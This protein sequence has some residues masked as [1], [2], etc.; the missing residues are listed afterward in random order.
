MKDFDVIAKEQVTTKPRKKGDCTGREKT[1]KVIFWIFGALFAFIGIV[2]MCTDGFALGL[3]MLIVGAF[4]VYNAVKYKKQSKDA[5]APSASAAPMQSTAPVQSASKVGKMHIYPSVVD[6][7]TVAYYYLLEFEP[8]DGV[9]IAKDILGDS[10]KIVDVESNGA[11]VTLIYNGTVFGEISDTYKAQM[12]KDFKKRGE[13]CHAILLADGKKVNLRFYKDK[14]KTLAKHESDI[15]QLRNFKG[16]AKQEIIEDLE[17]DDELDF[18]EDD[19]KLIVDY[20]GDEIG[21]LPSR[22]EKRVL[23]EDEEIIGVFV[24]HIE[25]SE[26]DDGDDVYIPFVKVFWE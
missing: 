23:E 18:D 4:L 24:D 2:A 9:D 3:I 10:E 8:K 15:V 22:I 20:A 5:P 6:G 25:E 13:P 19:G 21:R 14:L 11:I 17:P 12:V 1:L 7:C 16:K 26:N